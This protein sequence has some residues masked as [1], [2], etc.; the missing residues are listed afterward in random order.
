MTNETECKFGVNGEPSQSWGERFVGYLDN[1]NSVVSRMVEQGRAQGLADG[2][3]D[4]QRQLARDMGAVL[5]AVYVS[6]TGG[7]ECIDVLTP[8]EIQSRTGIV[9]GRQQ[10]L[11]EIMVRNG[12]I[13]SRAAQEARRRKN[14]R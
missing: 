10:G 7:E 14:G 3:L 13:K 5:D 12:M 2:N 8:E 4:N 6:E 11:I 1:P 9:P